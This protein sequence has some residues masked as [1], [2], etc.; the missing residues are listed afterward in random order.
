[1]ADGPK[2]PK[3]WLIA[4]IILLFLS[5][6]GCAAFGIGTASI[7][8]LADD[9]ADTNDF[10][11]PF[12]F[13]SESD[14]GAIVLLSEAAVCEGTDSGGS[15]ISF[16]EPS[17]NFTV[18]ANGESFNAVRT[19]DTVDGETYQ[20]VCGV[21]ARIGSYTVLKVPGFPGGLGG[22]AAAI[23]G[24]IV[25]GGLFF[26]LGRH[27]PDRGAGEAVRLEEAPRRGHGRSAHGR[28]RPAA[29]RWSG[30]AGAGM[31]PPPPGTGYAPPPAGPAQAPPPQQAPPPPAPPQQAPPPPAPPQ[32]PPPQAPPPPGTASAAGTASARRRP[33]RR[34]PR[35]RPRPRRHLRPRADPCGACN[36]SDDRDAGWSATRRHRVRCERE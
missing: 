18:D 24:G 3:G 17:G 8:G 13:T 4:G 33:H 20:L 6:G 29:T 5:L 25:L 7:V 19:F 36:P 1:M 26:V 34:R 27:L 35:L 31:A 16:D 11:T 22:L 15:P 12:T 28:V 2:P 30:P 10:G 21:E 32:A 23:G 14:A 9:V